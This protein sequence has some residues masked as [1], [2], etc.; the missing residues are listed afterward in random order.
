MPKQRLS[1]S[2]F[3]NKVREDLDKIPRLF[4][5]AMMPGSLAGIPDRII[6]YKGRFIAWEL[7]RSEADANKNRQGHTL[8]K[9]IKHLINDAGGVA[10]TVYP[11]NYKECFDEIL[12]L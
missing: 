10:R 8:Q 3:K 1:E 7:K 2:S 5:F 12:N 11:E 9:W 4:H 6:C